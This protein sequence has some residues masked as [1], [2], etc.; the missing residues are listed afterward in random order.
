MRKTGETRG[1]K[2]KPRWNGSGDPFAHLTDAQARAATAEGK[3]M[4]RY[5][6]GTRIRLAP[7]RHVAEAAG[8]TSRAVLGWRKRPEY[9]RAAALYYDWEGQWWQLRRTTLRAPAK[10]SCPRPDCPLITDPG[11]ACPLRTCPNAP[12][13]I[14]IEIPD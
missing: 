4:K 8:C 7:A 3:M 13:R 1:R 9:L 6:R 14:V 10:P 2:P 12:M 11:R 5:A